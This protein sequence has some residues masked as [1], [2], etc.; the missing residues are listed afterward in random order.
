ML[1]WNADFLFNL[2]TFNGCTFVYVSA[3]EQQDCCTCFHH[4]KRKYTQ[5]LG[6]KIRESVSALHNYKQQ[7][8]HDR[9]YCLD[10]ALKRFLA[11]DQQPYTGCLVPG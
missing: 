5:T 6:L 9:A 7:M 1:Q 4:Q 3:C 10:Q 11:R 8:P 2:Y